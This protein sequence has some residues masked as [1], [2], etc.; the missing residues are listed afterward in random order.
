M[1]PDNITISEVSKAEWHI[2]SVRG[3]VDGIT[4]DTLEAALKAAVGAHAQVAVDCSGIDYISSAGLRSL[5]EGARAAQ[6]QHKKYL[7]CSPSPRA[8]QVFDISRMHLVL[9]MQD[10]LP[11]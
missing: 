6:L 9:P 4:A 8:K 10:E 7:V 2:V 1:I 5:L 3:R 11:C